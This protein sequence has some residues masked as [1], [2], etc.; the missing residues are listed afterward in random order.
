MAHRNVKLYRSYSFT[1]TI[2]TKD[3]NRKNNIRDFTHIR[4]ND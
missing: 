3:Y 2:L 4:Q 1:I